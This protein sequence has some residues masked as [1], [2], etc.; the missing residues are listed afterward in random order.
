VAPVISRRAVLGGAAAAVGGIGVTGFAAQRVG[1][2]DDALRALGARPHA[3]P[4][5]QDVQLLADAAAGQ[6]SLLAR[7]DALDRRHHV[8][9]IAP[10]RAVLAAQL[11]AVADETRSPV[12]VPAVPDEK[13]AAVAAFADDIEAAAKSR[14]DGALVSG[15]LA[16]T[17]VL[18]SMAA[19]L[20]QVG[21]AVRAAA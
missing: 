8:A 19:G 3:E 5:P 10:L 7:F 11:A 15:S 14:H 21:L 6:R 16:V 2:L 17:Q 18:A 20:A 13:D 1:V 9:D 12:E 4:N